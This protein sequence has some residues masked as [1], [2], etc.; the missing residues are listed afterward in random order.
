MATDPPLLWQALAK[1]FHARTCIDVPHNHLDYYLSQGGIHLNEHF[2]E[3]AQRHTLTL[4][5]E[6]MNPEVPIIIGTAFHTLRSALDT[7]VST[8]VADAKGVPSG[9]ENF[10]MHS[11][12]QELRAMFEPGHRQ[13]SAC[14]DVRESKPAANTIIEYLPDLQKLIFET[15]KPWEDGNFPIWALGRLDNINKH[16]MIMPVLANITWSDSVMLTS[17]NSMNWKPSY[18]LPPG[19]QVIISRTVEPVTFYEKGTFKATLAFPSDIPFGG[20]PVFETLEELLQ[21]VT[22]IIETLEAQFKRT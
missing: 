6:P 18:T 16:R 22:G 11:T 12:E 2:D 7:A 19:N 1:A 8:L 13:C 21:L 10:P 4:V 17:N 15:F 20:K 5:T 9:R 3:A 14:G